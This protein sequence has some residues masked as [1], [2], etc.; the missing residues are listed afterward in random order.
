[1]TKILA[2]CQTQQ[3]KY[4]TKINSLRKKYP[5]IM[6]KEQNNITKPL[7]YILDDEPDICKLI[8]SFLTKQGFIIK[9]FYK[10]DIFWENIEYRLPDL[11]ILDIMLPD[12][13]GFKI[14]RR[15]RANKETSMIPIIMLTAK[16][17]EVD[18]ILGLEIG[19]DDY[20]IKPFSLRELLA[21]IK[22]VLRRTREYDKE[23]ELITLN[24]NLLTINPN[25]YEVLVENKKITLTPT[26]FKILYILAKNK[27]WVFTRQQLL[28]RIWGQ[29]KIV[30][31]RTIDVHIRNLRKK[32]G[33]ADKLIKN[34]R[35]IGYKIDIE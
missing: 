2:Y 35:G 24:N 9:Y 4:S 34:V 20:I 1:M 25:K 11:L 18:R 16:G 19:A 7:I 10:A 27:G 8:D 33:K 21:R 28:D 5:S 26:E 12:A 13:D 6:H 30:I 22:A 15:L 32:L 29:E 14:C 3:K 23:N 31:D 17:E